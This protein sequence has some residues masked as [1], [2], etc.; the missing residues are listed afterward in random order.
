MAGRRSTDG[1]PGVGA[2]PGGGRGVEAGPETG[3]EVV[4]P[5]GDGPWVGWGQG[6]TTKAW[7][8]LVERVLGPDDGLERVARLCPACGSPDHGPPRVVTRRGLVLRASASHHGE[9]RLLGL[10]TGAVGVD[11]ASVTEVDA[12][13]QPD[14]VLAPGE[15]A[16]T[17]RERAQLWAT[18]EAALKAL[19]TGLRR[20]MTSLRVADLPAH[21]LAVAPVSLPS[22]DGE[23]HAADLPTDPAGHAT[24]D[25][26]AANLTP[27]ATAGLAPHDAAG[28]V[29]RVVYASGTSEPGT[30]HTGSGI[31]ET[32]FEMRSR[33]GGATT[34]V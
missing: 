27:H 13:W 16:E 29:A 2:G 25:L 23:H 22:G 33:R 21:G 10:H 3:S 9:L 26:A 18:K 31:R 5:L 7:S 17:A 4:G 34:G 8:W 19:G 15:R 11:V 14:L 12:R 24:A 30:R 32:A 20:P 28:L 6:D 1:G